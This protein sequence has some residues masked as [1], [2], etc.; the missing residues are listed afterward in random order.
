M[1]RIEVDTMLMYKKKESIWIP[2][3]KREKQIRYQ[4]R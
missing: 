1:F 4:Y 3:N 2:M